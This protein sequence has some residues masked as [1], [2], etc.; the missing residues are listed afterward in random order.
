MAK[1]LKF[2]T[3]AL[4]VSMSVA[5]LALNEDRP[6]GAKNSPET[7][8]EQLTQ[9][10][11]G[12][13]VQG[14]VGIV[15][16]KTDDAPVVEAEESDS[17]AED[18]VAVV[19]KR[20]DATQVIKKADADMKKSKPGPSYFGFAFVAALLLGAYTGVRFW[21]NKTVPQAIDVSG[22]DGRT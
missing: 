1:H 4:A 22:R 7:S 12:Q 14:E 11:Q 16:M 17:T 18:N 15:P 9:M 8:Q 13:V 10:Q 2:L 3:I 19:E 21:A 20:D 5:A 6:P